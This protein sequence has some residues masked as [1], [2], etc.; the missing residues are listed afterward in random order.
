MTDMDQRPAPG[1]GSAS[2]TAA[3]Q[4]LI[5][6]AFEATPPLFGV[7]STLRTRRMGL[8]FR[9][10]TGRAE[11]FEWSSGRSVVQ[12]EGPLAYASA[13]SPVPLSEVEEALLAW[14]A[15]GP[16][17]IALAD[18]PVHGALSSLLSSAGRTIPSSSND[19]SVDLFL[20]ND[21]GTWLYRPVRDTLVPV[22]ITGPGDYWKILDWYRRGLTRLSEHRPDVGWFSAPEGTHNVNPL[23]PGQY[24]LNRPGSTWFLPVGDVGLE[25][26]NLLL[27]SYEWSGFYLMD[28]ESSK[29]AGCDEFIGPGFLEAGFP[30]PVFDEL[31]LLLHAGQVGCLVQNVRLAAEALG[32]GAWPVGSYADDLVLGAYPE[33]AKGLGFSFLER[34]A[35]RNPSCT[36]TCLGLPG[37]LE[38][39]VVPSPRF[40]TAADAVRYVKELR[41]QPGA[42]LSRSDGAAGPFN[43]PTRQ[44]LLENPRSYISDRTEAAVVRTVEYIVDRYGSCP[45]YVSP[46]RAKF[47]AQVHHVD[48]G[49]YRRFHRGDGEAYPVT[50]AIAAHFPAW[51]PGEPDP[52]QAAP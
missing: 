18:V 11:T 43:E 19:R 15:L 8:G 5:A 29:P 32:L 50:P 12:P 2:I 6:K 46:V 4:E 51:H 23:G 42:P 16:N 27:T 26:F 22:E 20:I 10:E 40:P 41:Y 21:G 17:G 28:A 38:P 3:E 1:Q 48:P 44:E 49:F 24:N 35:T 30:I 25:W 52:T 9:S 34:D 14:A 47:S 45:A 36:V 37:T 31:A 7:L 33:V 39:V 13:A